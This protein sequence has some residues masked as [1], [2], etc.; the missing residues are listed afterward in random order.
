M[1]LT[2]Q[3]TFVLVDGSLGTDEED[4]DDTG[5][6]DS[7]DDDSD[8]IDTSE[9][10]ADETA[11]DEKDTNEPIDDQ[12][13]KAESSE[14]EPVEISSDKEK[15]DPQLD[16]PTSEEK[17]STVEQDQENRQSNDDRDLAS[18]TD[19]DAVALNRN[20]TMLPPPLPAR[21]K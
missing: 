13:G 20:T 4:E 19:N 8:Y 6:E 3:L 9:E 12:S 18:Q 1:S 17:V 7:D 5:V 16:R 21:S 10:D 15:M 14:G 11:T 2:L